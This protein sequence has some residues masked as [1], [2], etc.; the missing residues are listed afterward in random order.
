MAGTKDANVISYSFKFYNIYLIPSQNE[1]WHPLYSEN[2]NPT[3]HSN[4]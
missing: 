3:V 4:T 1:V 2:K